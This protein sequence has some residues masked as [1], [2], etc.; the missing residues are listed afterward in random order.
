MAQAPHCCATVDAAT[1]CRRQAVC[2]DL[3]A[4]TCHTGGTVGAKD[5]QLLDRFLLLQRG[6][7]TECTGHVG[8]REKEGE[9][10]PEMWHIIKI[11]I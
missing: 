7:E 10:A 6:A 1:V 8:G 4:F 5:A 9:I 11:Q 2:S 3:R